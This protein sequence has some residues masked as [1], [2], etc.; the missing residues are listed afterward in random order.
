MIDGGSRQGNVAKEVWRSIRKK[1]YMQRLIDYKKD[2]L[3][4]LDMWSEFKHA[5]RKKAEHT[6]SW[7]DVRLAG[8][9]CQLHSCTEGR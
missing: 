5:V 4:L 1:N 3:K 2:V 6:K 8:M 9:E 7:K